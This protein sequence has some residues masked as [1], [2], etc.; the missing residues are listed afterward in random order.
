M[1]GRRGWK[2]SKKWK[3]KAALMISSFFIIKKLAAVIEII[4]LKE[5][6]PN[7]VDGVTLGVSNLDFDGSVNPLEL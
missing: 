7:R 6:F 2:T 3:M 5:F 1:Q 4:Y